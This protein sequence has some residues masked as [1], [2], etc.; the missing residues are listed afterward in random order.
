MLRTKAGETVT[1]R[2]P[3]SCEDLGLMPANCGDWD[4]CYDF[5]N[6]FAEKFGKKI[7]FQA[8]RDHTYP[9][10]HVVQTMPALIFGRKV[11]T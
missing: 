2:P 10:T 6:S 8:F 1:V 4:Q 11:N 5:E 9:Y 7:N 3:K